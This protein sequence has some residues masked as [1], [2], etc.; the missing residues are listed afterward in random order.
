MRIRP[1]ATTLRGR[2]LLSFALVSVLAVAAA[3]GVTTL[4]ARDVV[5]RESQQAAVS[6]LR[7]SVQAVGPDLRLPLDR[8]GLRLLV[9]QLGPSAGAESSSSQATY[10]ASF[11]DELVAPSRGPS[12]PTSIRREARTATSTLVQRVRVDGS[13][14]LAV[15]VPV[16]TRTDDSA[17]GVVV[18]SMT[19]LRSQDT[20][21][22]GIVK[23]SATAAVPVVVAAMILA[24]LVSTGLLRPVRRLHAAVEEMS[25]GRLGIQVPA[26][27]RGELG[28]LARSFNQMSRDLHDERETLRQMEAKARR[29]AADVSH[30]LRTPLSAMTAVAGLLADEADLLPDDIAEAATLVAEETHHLTR[31]VEELIEISRFDAG[32]AVLRLDEINLSELV[33]RSLTAR[34]WTARVDLDVPHELRISVDP[35]RIDVI[36]ANLVG[37]AVRHAGEAATIRLSAR[38]TGADLVIDVVD[39]GPGIPSDVRPYIFDRFVKGDP[40]RGGRS[41][42]SGLGLSIARENAELHGGSLDLDEHHDGGTRFV[43]GLPDVVVVHDD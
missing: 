12:V 22:D 13:T 2:L 3:T 4:Q 20:V 11:G 23:A 40:A 15:A 5:L 27:D 24:L 42:G 34:D 35:R 17:T 6:G 33:G 32:T 30:E 29:F 18:Y 28:D 41:E 19:S 9:S 38:A 43:L 8:A 31:L 37:N 14:Y 36:V 1:P 7:A 26:V 10:A 21:L 39:D 25:N 16:V